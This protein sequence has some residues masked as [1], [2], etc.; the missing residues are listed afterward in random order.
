MAAVR[1]LGLGVLVSGLLVQ[2]ALADPLAVDAFVN[3][4]SGPYADA[5]TLTSGNAQ[6]WY[7]S[8]QVANLFGGTP[9]AQQQQ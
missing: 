2:A 6:P 3:L 8:P 7:N 1:T 4:G 5:S 9:T